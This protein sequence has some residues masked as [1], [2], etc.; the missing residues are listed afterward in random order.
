[1]NIRWRLAQFWE[2]RWWRWYL[3]DKDKTVYLR[4]KAEYWDRIVAV[5]E[6][7]LSGAEAILD[8]GCG[9]AGIF[10]VLRGN[11]LIGVDPLLEKYQESLAHFDPDNYPQVQFVNS[12][13]EAY[14]PDQPFEIIFCCNVINHVADLGESLDKLSS[15]LKPGG[16]LILSI[17]VHN[18]KGLKHLFRLIPGDILHPHQHDLEDYQGMLRERGFRLEKTT[19]LKKGG[20][21]DYY[22]IKAISPLSV[23]TSPLVNSTSSQ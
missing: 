13:L 12:T 17:D 2:I 23:I 18:H 4:K 16:T 11:P 9:P 20:I 5:C 22:L 14:S 1:M 7:E 19:Q 15:W 6:L 10:M 3:R 21:F 8:A